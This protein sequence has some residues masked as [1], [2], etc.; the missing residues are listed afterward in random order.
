MLHISIIIV[1]FNS[2][3]D[4]IECLESLQKI[5][6][7][8]FKYSVVVVDNAS[9]EPFTLPNKLHSQNIEVIHS[10]SNLG[11]TG[12]NNMG[13]YYMI[14]KYNSD[15][16][17]LL[18]NDTIVDPDFLK[19]LIKTAD[20]NPR[21]GLVSSK[22]Y[23]TKGR[24]FHHDS[25]DK[26][27]LGN[28]LWYAGGSIDWQHLVAFHRGVDEV[29]YG[30]FDNQIE[31]DFATGCS[32]LIKREVL[33]KCGTLDKRFFVY[34]EDVDLSIRVKKAGYIIGFS[35]KSIVFHKNAGSSGGS[36]SKIH[37]YYQTRNRIILSMKNISFSNLVVA[38]RLIAKWLK[39]GNRIKRKAVFH[40]LTGQ[41]G[42]Q[43]IL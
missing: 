33:E 18:N 22:I 28:V 11:F 42:K 39:S 26:D 37:E 14:E 32:F 43:T 13:I 36:G 38:L 7:A 20:S 10:D 31:S 24:E 5:K 21:I 8:N 41:F 23:F 1:N 25:Y 9:I 27:Q 29:D 19:E 6:H 40:A 4:T 15:Y 17:L 3:K 30:Q 35:P 34:M 16:I 2:K 12:G